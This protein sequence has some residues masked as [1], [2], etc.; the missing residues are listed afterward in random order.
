MNKIE[1]NRDDSRIIK[2]EPNYFRNIASKFKMR[3]SKLNQTGSPIVGQDG[4]IVKY[5]A[6]PEIMYRMPGTTKRIVPAR[7]RTGGIN[8]GLNVLIRNPYKNSTSLTK[9]WED[10]FKGKDEVLL[11]HVLEHDLDYPIDYLTHRIKEGAVDKTRTDIKFF[12]KPESKPILDGNVTFL[13]MANELH[14]INYYTILAHKSIANTHEELEGGGN[15]DTEWY[16]VDEKAKEV[17][18]KSNSIRIVEGGAA[19]NELY[20]SDS[21]A[22]IQMVKVLELSEG[23]DQNIDKDKAFNSIY[24]YY[25]AGEDSF[26]DFIKAYKLWKD[27]TKRSEFITM[28]ELFDYINKGVVTY[29]RGAYTWS[30]RTADKPVENFTFM[31]KLEFVNDFLLNSQHQSNVEL[32]QEEYDAKI[33]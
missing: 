30:K 28:S 33:R 22:L 15:P 1:Y 7:M 6:T 26:N 18:K 21:D 8:T 10:I 3:S 31:S 2:I 29:K 9:E 32:L 4:K 19:L 17:R 24:T 11:Q 20:N 14:R 5:N 13:N 12:E 25:N 27:P 23:T 16:I